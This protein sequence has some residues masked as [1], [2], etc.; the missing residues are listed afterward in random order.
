M[1]NVFRAHDRLLERTVALKILHE[2]Y[3]RDEDYVE[4]FRR[5]ARAVAQ[6][7]HPNIVTVIDRGEQDGR[8]FIVFEY[9]DGREPQGT[10]GARAARRARGDRA[11]APGRARALVRARPGAR[12][13][14]RE[15]AERP[16]ERGRAG[17]G[18]G[19]RDRPLARR[20]RRH[21]D[22][23]RARDERLH[24]ARAGAR[25][26]GRSEDGHLLA[27]GGA[28]RAA[29]RRGAVLRATTSWRSRCATSASPRRACSSTGRTVRC[30]S[31]SRSSGR[32][33]RTRPTVLPRW[34][35]SAQSS[36]PASPSWTGAT[37]KARR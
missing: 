26:E 37:E 29:D 27:R 3:T 8:Q 4:R 33:R 25:P 34:A 14:G 36:R 32:W 17:E 11:R 18:D 1:S 12:A 28:L 13:P 16:A 5:E 23:D 15:A 7:T 31:T 9:V 24:R 35:S 21:A 2:Q 10:V 6:L 30:G 19:L 22:R 20:A